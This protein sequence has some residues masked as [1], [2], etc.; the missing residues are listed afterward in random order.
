MKLYHSAN[1][2]NICDPLFIAQY[3][4][5][6]VNTIVKNSLLPWMM[7]DYDDKLVSE[8]WR[9]RKQ[10][11]EIFLKYTVLMDL[12]SIVKNYKRN[13]SY[14]FEEDDKLKHILDGKYGLNGKI[15]KKNITLAFDGFLT[16]WLLT[17]PEKFKEWYEFNKK[18]DD[19]KLEYKSKEVM[20]YKETPMFP[21]FKNNNHTTKLSFN[22]ETGNYIFLPNTWKLATC[23][24]YYLNHPG[25]WT[26]NSIEKEYSIEQDDISDE[27]ADVQDDLSHFTSKQ[28][29]HKEEEGVTKENSDEEQEGSIFDFHHED[30][31]FIMSEDKNAD[32]AIM[33]ES[34]QKRKGTPVHYGDQKPSQKKRRKSCTSERKKKI[35]KKLYLLKRLHN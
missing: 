23:F 2:L 4:L 6:P 10:K 5:V 20:D 31:I 30:E 22:P 11:A 14:K 3:L 12:M 27:K 9:A 16:I 17:L 1:D 7:K 15:E 35:L 13:P 29:Q 8:K 26:T 21:V 18:E 28:E 24:K 34:R 25:E 32:S 19:E 33:Q